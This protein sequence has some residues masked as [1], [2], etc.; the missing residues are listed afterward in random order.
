MSVDSDPSKLVRDA[1][2]L[3][4]D[5]L[6]GDDDKNLSW[7][8]TVQIKAAGG[9]RPRARPTPIDCSRETTSQP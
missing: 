2:T 4:Y 9:S 6:Q 7:K 1:I 5:V 8:D 3:D